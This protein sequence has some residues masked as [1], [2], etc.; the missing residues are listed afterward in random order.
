MC[1]FSVIYRTLP[2]CPIFLL[3]NRDE[4][5]Q[6]PTRVPEVFRGSA[7]GAP[8]FGGTD[9][10]AGG[11]WLG[12]NAHGVVA[13]ITNRRKEPA[14][15]DP[16]SRGLL[17][18]DVMSF[19]TAAQAVEHVPRELSRR[20]YAGFN[21]I[22]LDTDS[23]W[24]I[25]A[26]EELRITRLDPGIHTIGNAPLGANRSPR[27]ARVQALVERMVQ[28]ERDWRPLIKRAKQI[29]GAQSSEG[30]PD[31]CLHGDGWG[32]VGSTIAALPND[33]DL[34]QYHYAAGPPCSTPYVDYSNRLREI[35]AR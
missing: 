2:E 25:E 17:C 21:L 18:R 23:F 1:V 10:R 22:V 33:R 15:V 27:D 34:S 19:S 7:G 31:I 12:I 3:T 4:S 29:L 16:R 11:T 30:L 5:T 13:A 14:P 6:R 8:W 24:V 35:L 26:A 20:A 9:A 28:E 32:T